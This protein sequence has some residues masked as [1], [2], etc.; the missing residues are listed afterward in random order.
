ME[1]VLEVE[2]VGKSFW[3]I[4][5]LDGAR[6]TVR[7]GEIH[8]VTGENG[9]GKST[10]MRIIAGSESADAGEVRFHGRG[11]AM[12]HQELLP[13]PDLTVAEN[14]CMGRE[15]VR[16]LSGWLDKR[17]MNREA[18]ELMNR[19]GVPVDPA[20]RMRDLTFAEQ[21]SVEIAKA[22]GRQADLII[23]DE[24]TSALSARESERLF[25]LMLDLKRRGV[26]IVYISHRLQEV[27]RLAD[28][29]TV[30]RDGRHV[31]TRPAAE[32]D[33]GQLIAMMVGRSLEPAAAVSRGRGRSDSRSA[34]VDEGR[35]VSAT[36]AS[37]CDAGRFWAWRDWWAPDG[38]MSRP[39]S[40]AWL[41]PP[42]AKS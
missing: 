1:P 10:L 37:R 13:F 16:R 7:K 5:A 8:A 11:I 12:I 9:A 31:A 40:S 30:M 42:A 27:F 6:L 25:D 34:R 22:L 17:A 3:G 29:I 39:P 38:R 32:L 15:P 35:P 36:S 2:G 20:R 23:M 21:Q 28:T 19:L 18:R 14:I 4:K 26:S 24:P 41:R 33:E